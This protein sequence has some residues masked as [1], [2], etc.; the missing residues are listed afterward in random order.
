MSTG[1]I[2]IADKLS[3]DRMRTTGGQ[4]VR[5]GEIGADTGQ[6]M[7]QSL[8]GFKE[9][10]QLADALNAAGREHYGHAAPAFAPA[11]PTMNRVGF[12]K[13]VNEGTEDEKI[14]HYVLPGG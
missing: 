8:H 1:E 6:G 3:E 7:F 13:V 12:S 11:Q 2:G 9:P 10:K 5:I 14:V 4:A